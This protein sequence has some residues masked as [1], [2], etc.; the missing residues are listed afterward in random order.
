MSNSSFKQ[1]VSLKSLNEFVPVVRNFESLSEMLSRDV[2]VPAHRMIPF[3][4]Y[5]D[6]VIYVCTVMGE[7]RYLECK[8]SSNSLNES[9]Q[10]DEEKMKRILSDNFKAIIENL[11]SKKMVAK[12]FSFVTGELLKTVKLYND[13]GTYVKVKTI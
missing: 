5:A 10:L 9:V 1:E 4:A 12:V 6:K 13:Q 7:P 11:S 8:R 2:S 3:F